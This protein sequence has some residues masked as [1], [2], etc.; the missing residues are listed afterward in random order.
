MKRTAILIAVLS[1]LTGFIFATP[2]TDKKSPP[3]QGQEK[4]ESPE[5]HSITNYYEPIA[6]PSPVLV[7]VVPAENSE[8][9][10]AVK[11]RDR[12]K[13]FLDALTGWS[14]LALAV[15]TFGLAVFTYKLWS[16]TMTLVKDAESTSKTQ[17]EDTKE[18]LRI[19]KENADSTR[20]M[21]ETMN[22]TAVVELR[23]YIGVDMPGG[24]RSLQDAQNFKLAA[25]D[26][27]NL[28]QWSR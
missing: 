8:E 1:A 13:D 12:D 17:S 10:A 24:T 18:Q 23:A 25:S 27:A 11:Q 26:S 4:L 19:A 21:V 14:T 20:L 7:K 16:A 9:S 2:P 22:N 3:E 15:I 6:L 28:R 5:I